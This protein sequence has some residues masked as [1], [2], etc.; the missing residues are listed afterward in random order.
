MSMKVKLMTLDKLTWEEVSWLSLYIIIFLVIFDVF[1]LVFL[2]FRMNRRGPLT[3]L[4]QP[5][6][7]RWAE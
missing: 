5:T 7:L 4:G 6:R 1:S 3:T 2:A